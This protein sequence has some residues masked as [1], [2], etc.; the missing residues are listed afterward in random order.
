M[1]AMVFS[2]AVVEAGADDVLDDVLSLRAC[3]QVRVACG[4]ARWSDR[5]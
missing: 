2:Q 4:S 1:M 5:T 3:L